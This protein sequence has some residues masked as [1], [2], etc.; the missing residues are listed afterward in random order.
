MLLYDLF[1]MALRS[2]IANLMRTFLTALGMITP[3]IGA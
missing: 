1:K 3:L 2:L